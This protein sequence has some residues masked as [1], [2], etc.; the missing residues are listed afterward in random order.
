VS[1][2]QAALIRPGPFQD[3]ILASR[4]VPG[5]SAAL[6]PWRRLMV[7]VRPEFRA[8]DLVFDPRDPAFGRAACAVAGCDRPR[9]KRGLCL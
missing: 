9:R 3:V 1:T 5:G 4:A 8:D 7:A 2:Q 6:C